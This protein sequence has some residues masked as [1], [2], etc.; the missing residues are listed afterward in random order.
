[1]GR[2][3]PVTLPEELDAEVTAA[4]EAGE[5]ASAGDAI[6]EAVA[7]WSASRHLDNSL[8]REELRRL[9]RE[10]LQ[11]GPGRNMSIEEIKE[12]ARRRSLRE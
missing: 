2:I 5:Y 10:G 7:A 3:V 12:E 4:V 11:S 9:W 6:A 8:D 1:M